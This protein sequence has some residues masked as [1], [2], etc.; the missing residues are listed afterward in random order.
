MNHGRTRRDLLRAGACATVVGAAGCTGL[1]SPGGGGDGGAA[2]TGWPTYQATPRNNAYLPDRTPVESEPSVDW[3]FDAGGV[4]HSVAVRDGTVY[5][6][7]LTGTNETQEDRTGVVY[8]VDAGSGE[9]QWRYEDGHS[10]LRAPTVGPDAVYVGG[11]AGVALDRA[12]GDVRWE[13]GPSAEFFGSPT[14]AD[15]T[16]HVEGGE[17]LYALRPDDGSVA[18]SAGLGDDGSDPVAVGDGVAVVGTLGDR[19]LAV[20]A[21]DGSDRWTVTADNWVNGTP[22]VVDGTV[23]AGSDDDRVYSVDAGDGTVRWRYDAGAN[24][25]R[26]VAVAGDTVL[27]ATNGNGLHAVDRGTGERR[28]QWTATEFGESPF[29]QAPVVVGDVVYLADADGTVRGLALDDG[30]EL[31]SVSPGRGVATPVVQVD[32]TLYVGTSWTTEDEFAFRGA[33]YAL[34]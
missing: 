3:Q 6:T 8:A 21:A 33:V 34:S 12:T 31:W 29:L 27:V 16:L 30:T 15:G 5:A 18:W 14:L 17:T 23:F 26:C 22:V 13:F 32:G 10:N 11:S 7:A 25:D 28:W 4:D 2:V 19:V 24:V 20:D 9:Q 1:L